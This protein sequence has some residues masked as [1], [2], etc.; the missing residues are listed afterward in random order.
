P[1]TAAAWPRSGRAASAPAWWRRWQ[2]RSAPGSASS[3]RAARPG[4]SPFAPR[5]LGNENDGAD[6]LAPLQPA[7]GSRRFG[8]RK[9]PVYDR[10]DDAAPERLEQPRGHRVK[11]G[12]VGGVVAEIRPRHRHRLRCHGADVPVPDRPGSLAEADDMAA[13]GDGFER[14]AEGVRADAVID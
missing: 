3:A 12:R 11:F 14:A 5:P 2:R 6:V 10:R 13:H 9:A 1:T 7:M 8:K 4:T